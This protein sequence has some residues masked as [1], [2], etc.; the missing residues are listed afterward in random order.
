MYMNESFERTLEFCHE[1]AGNHETPLGVKF[2]KLCMCNC[3]QPSKTW[4]YSRDDFTG[5][6]ALLELRF[7]NMSNWVIIPFLSLLPAWWCVAPPLN[8]PPLPPVWLS[9]SGGNKKATDPVSGLCYFM[10]MLKGSLFHIDHTRELAKC[11]VNWVLWNS[12][13]SGLKAF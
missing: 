1:E 9:L 2:R 12:K 13:P 10:E 7:L 3:L 11:G 8:P 5:R 6:K 4:G